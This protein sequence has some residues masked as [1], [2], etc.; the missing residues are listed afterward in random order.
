L[1]FEDEGNILV[2]KVKIHSP[3]DRVSNPRGPETSYVAFLRN[4]S[5]LASYWQ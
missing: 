4:S 5:P 3:S 2:R 1:T